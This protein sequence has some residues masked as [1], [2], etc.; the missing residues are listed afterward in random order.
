MSSP[1]VPPLAVL[2]SATIQDDFSTVF[3]EVHAGLVPSDNVWLSC[4]KDGEPSVHGKITAKLHEQDRDRVELVGSG[5][6][7]LTR[8]SQFKYTTRCAALGIQSVEI[9]SPSEI[10]ADPVHSDEKHPRQITSFV[11]SGTIL[12]TA[13]LDGT[14]SVYGLPRHPRI[15]APYPAPTVHTVQPTVSTKLHKSTINALELISGNSTGLLLA[16]AG[17]DFTI[18]ITPLPESTGVSLS[19]TPAASLTAHMRSVTALLPTPG[20]PS[21][22]LSSGMDGSLRLWDVQTG[23]QKAMWLTPKPALSLA[24]AAEDAGGA[25]WAGLADGSVELLDVRARSSAARF[26]AGAAARAIAAHADG[27]EAAVGTASGTGLLFD[28]R[29][30]RIRARW[31]RGGATVESVAFAPGGR[32]VVGGDDGLPYVVGLTEGGARV[33]EELVFGNVEAVRA[34]R[35]SGGQVHIAGDGGVIRKYQL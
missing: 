13:L 28:V 19:L 8:A 22:L 30:D 7:E 24:G 14:L 32:V 35:V 18:H 26:A 20:D 34:I 12:A 21:T 4:Y 6:V 2:P 33:S 10:Y 25:A 31:R 9:I 16:S 11:A 3:S 17:S 1:T 29:G 5:G 15:T 27:S 23:S